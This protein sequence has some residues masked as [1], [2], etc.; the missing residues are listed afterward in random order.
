MFANYSSKLNRRLNLFLQISSRMNLPNLQNDSKHID[1]R[2]LNVNAQ[3][4]ALITLIELFGNLTMILHL[5]FV[6]SNP[7][8]AIIHNMVFYDIIIP[9]AL[10]ANTNDNKNRI[11]NS[12]WKSIFKNLVGMKQDLINE[13]SENDLSKKGETT[14]E[15][16]NCSSSQPKADQTNTSEASK[17]LDDKLADEI[18]CT[19]DNENTTKQNKAVKQ[20]QKGFLHLK[21]KK[22][23][24]PR[25]YSGVHNP[26]S[27]VSPLFRSLL[28]ESEPRL[29]YMYSDETKPEKSE[30]MSTSMNKNK[31]T[32]EDQS[33]NSGRAK[34]QKAIGTSLQ[35]RKQLLFQMIKDVQNEAKYFKSLKLLI[36]FEDHRQ[37]GIILS[38]SEL[39]SKYISKTLE[40]I[41]VQNVEERGIEPDHTRGGHDVMFSNA[42]KKNRNGD[43]SNHNGEKLKFKGKPTERR[44][45]RKE[46]LCRYDVSNYDD[47][48]I[49]YLI[50]NLIKLEKS[51]LA[52]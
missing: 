51:L 44:R 15:N 13:I 29:E 11:I 21:N 47:Q 8:S 45:M 4:T 37:E 36:L 17:D 41:H 6:E 32:H 12:G 5:F 2:R 43:K 20:K 27:I 26:V 16:I 52:E 46:L 14:Q 3:I 28:T 38:I 49:E 48:S 1:I 25:N 42:K 50:E 10:L 18:Q 40:H 22:S 19:M 35:T 31:T 9:Y 34:Y 7:W 24:I 30:N 39:N 33:I 23:S